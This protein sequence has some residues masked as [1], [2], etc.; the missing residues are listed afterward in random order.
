[1]QCQQKR[2]VFLRNGMLD[3]LIT[4]RIIHIH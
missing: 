3:P 1:M 2:S 4:N